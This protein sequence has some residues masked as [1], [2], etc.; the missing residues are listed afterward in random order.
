MLSTYECLDSDLWRFTNGWKAE[1]L[2]C[3]DDMETSF[4][5]YLSYCL[6]LTSCFSGLK[7]PGAAEDDSLI[8]LSVFEILLDEPS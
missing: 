4:F 6:W 7:N 3:Y 5:V 2:C 1:I 8:D